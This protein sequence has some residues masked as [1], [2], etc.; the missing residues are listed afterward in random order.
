MTEGNKRYNE[1]QKTAILKYRHSHID[2]YNEY[3]RNYY[4]LKKENAEWNENFKAK[5]KE[6]SKRYR[7]NHKSSEIKKR[8]RPS[9]GG[10]ST[11]EPAKKSL[12]VLK[13]SPSEVLASLESDPEV[14]ASLESDPE[15]IASL[16]NI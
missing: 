16:E 8:G 5:C 6:A 12:E 7:L 15:V 1:N 9:K 10:S 3:Q 13:N 2:E 4:H 11:T 14:I